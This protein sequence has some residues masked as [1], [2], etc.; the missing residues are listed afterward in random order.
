MGLGH[1]PQRPIKTI[2][3]AIIQVEGISMVSKQ[4]QVNLTPI[5]L[6]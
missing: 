6:N 2:K 1:G 4:K 5:D 3:V